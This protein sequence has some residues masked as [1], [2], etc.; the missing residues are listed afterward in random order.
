MELLLIG[1]PHDG[2]RFAIMEKPVASYLLPLKDRPGESHEYRLQ[3][4]GADEQIIP[5]LVS[6]NTS[7]FQALELLIAGYK[8][9]SAKT[10]EAR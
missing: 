9:Q 1:G 4:L 3:Y 7:N 8:T 6:S 2:V 5:V 10:A